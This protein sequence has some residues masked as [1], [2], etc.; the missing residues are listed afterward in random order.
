[1]GTLLFL[2]TFY[3]V[4]AE[5]SVSSVILDRYFMKCTLSPKD[6][7][8]LSE[9]R[10]CLTVVPG[11]PVYSGLYG[12][13]GNTLF[14]LFDL[15]PHQDDIHLVPLTLVSINDA[16]QGK[17]YL[18]NGKLIQAS[19]YLKSLDEYIHGPVTRYVY[20]KSGL[21]CYLPILD[22]TIEID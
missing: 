7:R 14:A 3:E 19:Q 10:K 20:D 2:R 21:S 16:L 6:R 9:M 13:T 15:V 5:A 1:M 17:R 4:S 11:K 8:M 12:V 22:L 18:E